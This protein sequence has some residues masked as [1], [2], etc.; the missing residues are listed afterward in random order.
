MN[1]ADFLKSKSI[2]CEDAGISNFGNIRA[3][4]K[5]SY[6]E[7]AERNLAAAEMERDSGTLFS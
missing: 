4:L 2:S 3:E 5:E 1:Y 7:Q 6:F